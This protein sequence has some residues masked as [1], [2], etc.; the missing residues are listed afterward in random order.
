MQTRNEGAW[1]EATTLFQAVRAGE[2]EVAM[3]LLRTASDPETVTL[4]LLRMLAV[5]LRGEEAAKLDHFIA[6]ARRAGP[7]PTP[8]SGPKLPP[9][10]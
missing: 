3:Q 7:P 9:L 6:A 4:S 10:L 1:I 5:Y 2:H 8:G